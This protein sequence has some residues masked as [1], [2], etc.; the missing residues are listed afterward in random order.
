MIEL[1]QLVDTLITILLLGAVAGI[2]Y[3]FYWILKCAFTAVK[4]NDD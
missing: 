4:E 1:L 2:F 3:I